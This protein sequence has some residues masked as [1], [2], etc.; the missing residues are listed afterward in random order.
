MIP[1]DI[2]LLYSDGLV[3]V[4]MFRYEF[5]QWIFKV[6]KELCWNSGKDFINLDINF[7]KIAIFTILITRMGNCSIFQYFLKFL[8]SKNLSYFHTGTQ[9]KQGISTDRFDACVNSRFT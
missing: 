5:K 6:G 7:G 2:T 8:S 9:I 4:F 3:W 1:P